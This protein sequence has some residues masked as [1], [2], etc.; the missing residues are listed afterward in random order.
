MATIANLSIGLGADSARLNKDLTKAS[1]RTKKWSKS[2]Q[3]MAA[4]VAVALGAVAA[5]LGTAALLKNADALSKHSKALGLTIEQYQGMIFAAGQAG[6]SQAGFEKGM[7]RLTA[8]IY[9][10]GRGLST[11]TDLFDDLGVSVTSFDG[12]DAQAQYLMVIKGLE[13]IEDATLR[14]ALAEKILGK[15]YA[16]NLINSDEFLTNMDATVK[17][18][19]EAAAAAERLNDAISLVKTSFQAATTN[20][21]QPFMEAM[22]PVLERFG[23]MLK[24]WPELVPILIRVGTGLMAL[25]GILAIVTAAQVAWNVAVLANPVVAVLAAITAAVVV[26]WPMFKDT[27]DKVAAYFKYVVPAMLHLAKAEFYD[28]M[29][30]LNNIFS[31]GITALV[32]KLTG[33]VTKVKEAIAT[34]KEFLGLS[35]TAGGGFGTPGA[36]SLAPSSGSSASPNTGRTGLSGGGGNAVLGGGEGD[37]TMRQGGISDYF[38]ELAAAE[39]ASAGRLS[40]SYDAALRNISMRGSLPNAGPP[41]SGRG[42]GDTQAV[43]DAVEAGVVA[44]ISGSGGGGGSVAPSPAIAETDLYK[45]TAEQFVSGLKSSFTT[46]LSTGDWK[47]FLN[48]TLDSFTMGIIS[49]FTEGLFK[50]FQEALT[51]SIGDMFSGMGGGGFDLFGSIGSVFGFADGGIVPTTSTSKSYADTVPAM[52]QPGELV[53]PKDQV[54]SFMGGGGSG[55]GQTFNINVTGDIS[56]LTRTEIVKMMPEIAAGTNM[57]NKESGRR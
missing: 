37:D 47:G 13:G 6:V 45:S 42:A 28:F 3:A 29:D 21:L 34:F 4:G 20:A 16:S 25:V 50:P 22:A 53:V 8:T 44:G 56:R 41:G 32:D 17:V 54:D 19:Q 55:G 14:R 27:W 30:R 35:N 9:D 39:R 52:L 51:S 43:Q 7:R 23:V 24:E 26:F 46:A 5:A 11:A 36:M 33:F 40:N 31:G 15:E 1:A 48:S 12:K 57:L 10:A 49:S 2:T 38:F 18:S